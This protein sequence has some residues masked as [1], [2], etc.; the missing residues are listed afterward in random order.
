MNKSFRRIA[1]KHLVL[2][3]IADLLLFISFSYLTNTM[4]SNYV[5]MADNGI[6]WLYILLFLLITLGFFCSSFLLVSLIFFISNGFPITTKR[7]KQMLVRDVSTYLS[8]ELFCVS[9]FPKRINRI[10]EE[11]YNKISKDD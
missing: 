1:F 7:Y 5:T 4:Q 3:L 6:L 2:P 11:F 10:S 8:V 9:F